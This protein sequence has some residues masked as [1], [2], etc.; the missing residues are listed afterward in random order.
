[1]VKA[2]DN[3]TTANIRVELINKVKKIIESDI[4]KKNGLTN[5]NQFI[6]WAVKEKIEELERTGFKSVTI[7]GDIIQ[8]FDENLGEYGELVTVIQNKNK[9]KC[10]KCNSNDCPHV[11]YI[12]VIDHIA[13]RLE[14]NGFVRTEKICPE[15][16]VV[17]R[18]LKIDDIFGYRKSNNQLI[19]Q[20]WCRN[21]RR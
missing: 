6:D 13:D 9:L 16:G 3:W 17:A 10:S 7:E 18:E 15:C 12:W 4:G 1:M 2:K 20:S 11:N 21:C 14:E 8:I 19:T 5:A